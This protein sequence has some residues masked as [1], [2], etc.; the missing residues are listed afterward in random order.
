MGKALLGLF[1]KLTHAH[2]HTH[3][4][5]FFCIYINI[6]GRYRVFL[7]LRKIVQE[8]VVIVGQGYGE[9]EYDV[10]ERYST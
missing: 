1:N 10:L 6:T 8:Y 2:T 7:E 4:H 5:T 3:L 9:R